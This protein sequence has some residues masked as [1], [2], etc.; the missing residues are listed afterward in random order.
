MIHQGIMVKAAE[1]TLAKPH[2]TREYLGVKVW[3]GK[4]I[5]FGRRWIAV[6]GTAEAAEPVP[7]A[8]FYIEGNAC[9]HTDHLWER[10][11]FPGGK[12]PT[13]DGFTLYL[14]QVIERWKCKMD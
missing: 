9:I 2:I 11:N 8:D 7:E 1:R 3:M 6:L 4:Q 13:L 10:I 5:H 12:E 14:N